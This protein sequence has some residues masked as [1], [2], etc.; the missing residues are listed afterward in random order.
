[1]VKSLTGLSTIRHKSEKE[2][3]ITIKLGYANA[4]VYKTDDIEDPI[5]SFCSRGSSQPD[6]WTEDIDG[7]T[8][9]WKVQRHISFV[10]CPGRD[11]CRR[12]SCSGMYCRRLS[13]VVWF[14]WS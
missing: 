1:M 2:R 13:L 4:K 10:D 14:G 9:T 7:K 11:T 6:E 3:N 5:A 8:V 12:R